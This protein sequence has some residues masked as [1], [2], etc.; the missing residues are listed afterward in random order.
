M[1]LTHQ[2]LFDPLDRPHDG[3]IQKMPLQNYSWNS[4]RAALSIIGRCYAEPPLRTDT[5]R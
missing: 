5:G 1:P 4:A 2:R 3:R